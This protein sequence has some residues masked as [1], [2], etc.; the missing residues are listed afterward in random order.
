MDNCPISL[1]KNGLIYSVE[2]LGSLQRPFIFVI[3]DKRISVPN[4][5]L[6]NEND[7]PIFFARKRMRVRGGKVLEHFVYRYCIG[8]RHADGNCEKFWIM[9]N[10]DFDGLNNEPDKEVK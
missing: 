3:P 6:V 9:P 4:K 7:Q 5:F 2:K 1:E 8:V 10:G